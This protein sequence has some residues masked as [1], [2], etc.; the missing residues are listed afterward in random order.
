M[1]NPNHH[2]RQH[3]RGGGRE[4][5]SNPFW[6]FFLSSTYNMRECVNWR[7]WVRSKKWPFFGTPLPAILFAKSVSGGPF[8]VLFADLC[9]RTASSSDGHWLL[10]GQ[11]NVIGASRNNAPFGLKIGPELDTFVLYDT[12]EQEGHMMKSSYPTVAKCSKFP[13]LAIF[14]NLKFWK[15]VRLPT[16]I[17]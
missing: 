10:V 12:Y 4:A 13:I 17:W 1:W 6:G 7:I 15:W 14:N 3:P 16:N 8:L 11:R 5:L 9:G 2:T